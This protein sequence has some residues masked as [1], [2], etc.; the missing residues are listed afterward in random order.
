MIEEVLIPTDGSD[1]AGVAIDHGL[2]L[3]KRFDAT[4]HVLHV[5]DV[6]K[7]ETAPHSEAWHQRG[8]EYVASVADDASREGITVETEI[9][10][11]YPA[12]CILAYADEYSIDLVAMGTH[13]RTGVR[14]YV[15]GSVAESVIRL[16]DVPVLTVR[17]TEHRLHHF[18]YEDV[19]VPTDGSRGAAVATEW[20]LDIAD[21]Y[22][23]TV[24]ALSVID[25]MSLGI[26]VRSVDRTQVLEDAAEEA[27]DDVLAAARE[28]G[29]EAT[30]AVTEGTPYRKIGAYV[31][32]AEIDLVI[33]GTN[34]ASDLERYLVG[35]VT[36]RMVRTSQVP[37]VTVRRPGDG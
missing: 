21:A 30:G 36:D 31:D 14:R 9:K 32:E 6:Q 13:G 2:D 12:D 24:H 4:A 25:P 22:D 5:V 10:T 11:G 18:P 23:A 27:V 8:E 3:A 7:T 28:A 1:E 34:G 19:L 26:D 37:V 29:L 17:L 16:A 33:M 20:A 15:L 35:G